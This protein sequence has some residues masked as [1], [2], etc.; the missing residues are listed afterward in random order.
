MLVNKKCKRGS[1]SSFAPK[2]HVS[3]LT[4]KTID[5]HLGLED[6]NR[7]SIKLV[8]RVMPR[9]TC[10]SSQTTLKRQSCWRK[11]DEK[12]RDGCDVSSSK[13]SAAEKPV[14]TSTQRNVDK[15]LAKQKKNKMQRRQTKWLVFNHYPHQATQSEEFVDIRRLYNPGFQQID[16]INIP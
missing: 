9:I 5:F 16:R 14:V 3:L 10:N 12:G 8:Q 15:G 13:D 7:H 1:L 11:D 6:W 4:L 2:T